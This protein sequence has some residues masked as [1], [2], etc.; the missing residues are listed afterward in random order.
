MPDGPDQNPQTPGQALAGQPPNTGDT[1]LAS[2]PGQP[3]ALPAQP[4]AQQQ[5]QAPPQP[6]PQQAAVSARHHALGQVTS[7]LFG[8]QRD[9]D[10]GAPVKQQPGAIF[11]S[12]LAGAMLGGALGSENSKGGLLGGLGRGASGVEQQQ[13]QR[14]QDAQKA[15]QQKAHLTLEQQQAQDAHTLNEANVAKVTAETASFHHLEAAQ[16][17]AAI[18]KKNA[19]S[20]Q[21]QQTLIE[22]G[23]RIAPIPIDGKVAA[24]GEYSAPDIAKAIIRD[25]SILHGPSGTIRHFVD[26]HDASDLEYVDGK[27]W[28]NES[29]D[30]VDM[31]KKTMVKAYDV[32]D[33][34]YGKPMQ[35]T[36]KDINAIA[37]YQLI[38]KDQE[39]NTYN[40][41]LN[42]ITGLYAQNLKNIN[43]GAQAKQ[44]DAAA[45]KAAAQAAKA[46]AAKRGTPAQFA[47]AEAKR[48]AAVAKALTAYQKGDLDKDGYADAVAEANDSYQK[49]F[50]LLNGQPS[51]A[52][53]TKSG[54]AT[55]GAAPAAKPKTQQAPSAPPAGATMKVPGDDGKLHWSDG[56]TDLGVVQ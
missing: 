33:N 14:Q 16:D 49:Q 22:A 45:A 4:P 13:Y 55:P 1:P 50:N 35:R 17:Q 37:G 12:L 44:R 25:P 40:V 56:K 41:P 20:K 30:L 10:T 21:Y 47:Q 52:A 26:L 27:G 18:D 2:R 43:Q 31:S 34:S 36:G 6:T 51:S 29:G 48:S 28:V 15:A 32:P 11:R 7:F 42:A 39:N 9:P 46:A 8:Q 24:N 5:Q 54:G 38:P 23:G 3:P 53:P 19:A